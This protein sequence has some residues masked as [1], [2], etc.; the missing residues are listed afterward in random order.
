MKRFFLLFTITFSLQVHAVCES[1]YYDDHGIPHQ[2][3]KS[4]Q[5]FYYCFGFHHGND[6]AWQMDYFRRL[7]LGKN[8]EVMGIDQ[9]KSDFMMRLLNIPAVANRVYQALSPEQKQILRWY[10][11]GVNE[12]FVTGKKAQE[13]LDLGFEPEEWLPEHSI[14]VMLLQSFDQT[15]KTFFFDVKEEEKLEV[16]PDALE[17]FRESTLPWFTSILKDGEYEKTEKKVVSHPVK[18]PLKL[19]ADF[20]EVFGKESGSN[21]WVISSK[22][23]E[24]KKAILA[25][26]PHLDLKTPLF[27]Y[28]IHLESPENKVI[29]A[30]L[31]GLPFI[32]SGTN[33]FVSWG[34]TNSYMNSA[35]SVV[36]SDL[37]ET[38]VKTTL[39]V[40]WFKFGF[41]K[42]PFFFKSLTYYKEMYPLLPLDVPGKQKVFLRWSG[43][44]LK[45]EEVVPMFD[46]HKARDVYEMDQVLSRVGVPS[47]NFVFADI[48]GDIG[49]RMVGL[50]YE[51][52]KEPY[53]VEEMKSQDFLNPRLLEVKN[54]PGIV[55]PKRNYIV[56]ANNQHWPNDSKFKGGS[57]YSL[58]FRAKRI[59]D[60]IQENKKHNI[61]VQRRIQCDLVVPDAQYFV[62]LIQKHIPGFLKYWDFV[63]RDESREIGLYRRLMDLM[64]EKWNADESALYRILSNL[65]QEKR[66]ELDNMY[67]IAFDEIDNRPWTE[68]IELPFEHLSGKKSFRYS[69][70]LAGLGDK[71]TVGPGT[72]QWDE[73]RKKYV[74]FSGASMR[75]IIEMGQPVKILLN[76]PGKN[77][78]YQ[79]KSNTQKGPWQEWRACEHFEVAF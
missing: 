35:D 61:E 55:K 70:L 54:R 21:N 43:H 47:W 25:N 34:L 64:M 62:P 17:L 68:I 79:S 2:K 16:Y 29:G 49:Y 27:W 65:S 56:T 15:K 51:S 53:G 31:P 76:L 69:P 46:V 63:A 58:S 78:D 6:R 18:K 67:K 73:S 41:L 19:W 66:N 10:A 7:A 20:P 45:A 9:I 24:N 40:I 71:H 30:S 48:K 57:A 8:A 42:L 28:W 13:F 22:L 39:P 52:T 74:H 12:G 14:Y 50:T 72:A 59:E 36:I 38:D 33:G 60:L 37:E 44:L 1:N 11:D 26:D 32:A 75:M 5:E 3:V 77:R 4:E 23:T